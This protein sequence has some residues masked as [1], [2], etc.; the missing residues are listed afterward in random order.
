[1]PTT[2]LICH[3][4]VAVSDIMVFLHHTNIACELIAIRFINPIALR[5]AKTPLSF[6]LSECNRV[7]NQ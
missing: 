6:G 3:I 1:M 5:T 4:F 7:N 2:V